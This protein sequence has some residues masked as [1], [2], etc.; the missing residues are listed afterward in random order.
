M[1][2]GSAAVVST[3]FFAFAAFMGLSLSSVFLVY[4]TYSITF[5]F[6]V[7]SIAF[8]A[9]SLWGYVTKRDLSGVGKFLLMGLVA[10]IIVMIAQLFIQSSVMQS[11]IAVIG[12]LIFAGLTAFETQRIKSDYVA[13]VAIGDQDWLDKAAIDGAL[14]LYISLL[15]IFQFLLMLLGQQE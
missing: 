13:H 9:M 2:R 4:T 6:L 1:R 8:M 7:A 12:T 15:N 3:G 5:T 14:G 10:L 11:A